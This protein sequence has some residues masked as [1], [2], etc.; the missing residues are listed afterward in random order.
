MSDTYT[1]TPIDLDNH[2]E[3][4]CELDYELDKEPETKQN[5][6]LDICGVCGVVWSGLNEYILGVGG[7]MD[8]NCVS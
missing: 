6:A 8:C 5:E 2:S 4:D 7:M 3:L 1:T